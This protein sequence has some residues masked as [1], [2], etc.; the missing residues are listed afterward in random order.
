MKKLFAG[1]KGLP[2][3]IYVLFVARIINAIGAF[4]H[5]LL[6]LIMTEKLGLTEGEAGVTLTVLLLAQ[7]PAMLLGGKLAD[8]FGRRRLLIIFQSLGAATYI[9]C[10]LLPLSSATV[11]IVVLAS[12][13]YAF[14]YPAIDAIAIDV[15][16]AG[17]RKEAMSLLYM[18]INIGFAVGPVLG[19][20]LFE[21][22]L[23][24]VFIGDALTTIAAMA[25][26]IIFVKE[27]L[28]DKRN[29]KEI[30]GLEKHQEGSVFK[31]LWQRKVLLAFA[32]ILTVFHFVYA[33]MGFALPLQMEDLFESGAT[34]FAF[35]ISFNGVLVILTTPVIT[36]V[37]RKWKPLRGTLVG[38][39][40]YAV[41]LGMLMFVRSLPLFYVSMF[42]FTIGEVVSTIDAQ[43][44]I[45]NFSPSSH[46]GRL[47]SVI[48]MFS[49]IG[50]SVSPLIV[51]Q[52]VMCCTIVT[53]WA[54]VS[55]T[56]VFGA[57][58]LVLVIRNRAVIAQLKQLEPQQDTAE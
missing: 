38:G 1:Y 13:F 35:L 9:L 34:Q 14:S 51:G 6:T 21:N 55:G 30:D 57:L 12:C 42:L 31:V 5:P 48:Y 36:M 19:G 18:G 26:V 41:S 58:L 23:P 27:T 22:H 39:L 45:A 40:L 32:G 10:G 2:R 25:L 49:G 17:N 43:A 11:Y 37:L 56:A 15:T 24:F 4:V 28:P 47:N 50:R 3:E 44:F 7:A 52:I 8:R 29:A 53:A 16:H 20:L 54:A 33:Q 46:R